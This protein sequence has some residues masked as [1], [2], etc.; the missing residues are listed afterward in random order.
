MPDVLAEAEA[1]WG[2]LKLHKFYLFLER[3]FHIACYSSVGITFLCQL[4][5]D[6][7]F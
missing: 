1:F 2:T 7:Y 6:V 4:L 3:K 5:A